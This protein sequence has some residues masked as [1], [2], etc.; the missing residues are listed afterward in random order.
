MNLK[1]KL[2]PND[3]GYYSSRARIDSNRVGEVSTD[4]S[5]VV[6]HNDWLFIYDGSNNYR[7]GY[8]DEASKPMGE[9][10][11]RLIEKRQNYCDERGISFIQVVVPN[12]ASV[13]NK[14]F[15]E[16]LE[17]AETVIL[18][19]L[20]EA[21][22]IANFLCPLDSMRNCTL[23]L[24]IFRRNDSHLTLSGNVFLAESILDLYGCEASYT[25]VD[26][27]Q[28][29]EIVHIGDLGCKFDN[30][31]EEIFIAPSF[32]SGQLNLNKIEKIFEKIDQ[33]LNGTI[34]SFFN[35][36]ALIKKTMLVFGNSF[37]EKVPS[38]GVS[39][40]FA[41]LFERYIFCWSASLLSNLIDEY[42]PD[43]VICQTCERF[44]NKLPEDL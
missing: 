17:C 32:N 34:Q 25:N 6:G 8:R 15:P 31:I 23:N 13:I 1:S 30:Q 7:L 11:A 12:K 21:K 2:L 27:I 42:Q 39:P 19:A 4:R 26:P 3:F 44:L 9:Q 29:N 41:S 33:G 24:F 40:I 18:K 37:F 43:I 38:W 20:L 28:T 36:N 35:K 10:W 16:K 22:P 5:S 14:F